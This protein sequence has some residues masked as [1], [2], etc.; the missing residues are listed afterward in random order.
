MRRDSHFAFAATRAASNCPRPMLLTAR[1]MSSKTETTATGEDKDEKK[2]EETL[3]EFLTSSCEKGSFPL[4]STDECC[5][6]FAQIE[7]VV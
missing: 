4:Q 5:K 6:F 7:D 2:E 3:R 1:E